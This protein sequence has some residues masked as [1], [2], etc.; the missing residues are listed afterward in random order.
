MSFPSAPLTLANRVSRMHQLARVQGKGDMVTP[1]PSSPLLYPFDEKQ[2]TDATH[3]QDKVHMYRTM[4][5]RAVD[6]TLATVCSS[7]NEQTMQT[8]Q[9]GGSIQSEEISLQ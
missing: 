6:I 2:V 7:R 9:T 8:V 3:T 4:R 1:V 5:V